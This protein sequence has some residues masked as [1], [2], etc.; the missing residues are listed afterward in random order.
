MHS[1]RWLGLGIGI[2]LL[3]A[4]PGSACP[5]DN[6]E[7]RDRVDIQTVVG[8][9][10]IDLLDGPGEAP[11]TVAN[12]L[13][14]VYRGDYDQTFFHRSL[15]GFVIQGGGYRW[16]SEEGYVAVPKDPP[17]LNE[18]GISN[19]RGTVAMA[20]IAGQPDSAT[21]QWFINLADN[22]TLD[23]PGNGAFT[24]FGRVVDEDLPVVDAIEALHTES[25]QLAVDSPLN[26]L[27]THLPVLEV[28]ERDPAGYGCLIVYPDPLPSNT[29]ADNF[30]AQY[31][32][33]ACA[34]Q[35]E[36]EVAV[37]LTIAAMDPQVPERLVTI[38]QAVPEPGAWLQLLLGALL[39]T[40][41]GTAR[42]RR[43]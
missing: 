23:L 20:K 2:A 36:L 17:I 6:P 5:I 18:P 22:V 24:V 29:S 40:G 11:N 30:G 34:T 14:Y 1:G 38:E 42:A 19:L 26:S 21:S 25:G 31:D 7:G 33:S 39:L 37:M 9:I 8:D 3:A 43:R 41:T 10:C 15:S 32:L 12:F 35:A 16:T 28:L 4:G 27:F 13:N